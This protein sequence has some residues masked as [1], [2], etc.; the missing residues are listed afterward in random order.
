MQPPLGTF[1]SAAA[2]KDAPLFRLYLAECMHKKTISAL[3]LESAAHDSL[4]A[5]CV[6]RAVAWSHLRKECV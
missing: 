2:N 3:H 1:Y 6:L 5:H 4:S